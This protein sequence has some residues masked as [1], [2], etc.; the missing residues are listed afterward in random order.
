[1]ISIIDWSGSRKTAKKHPINFG[2]YS[3]LC[4]YYVSSGKET[5]LVQDILT[6]FGPITLSPQCKDELLKAF[7][8]IGLY[9]AF[10]QFEK[11]IDNY[12]W[13]VID[14]DEKDLSQIS[15]SWMG[16]AWKTEAE[17][18]K[19]SLPSLKLLRAIDPRDWLSLTAARIEEAEWYFTFDPV[20]REL[21]RFFGMNTSFY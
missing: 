5:V 18:I 4:A 8:N 14:F 11:D 2:G 19:R 6:H 10:I 17:R 1:M 7:I 12:I 16:L 3:I 21:A 9:S 15:E 13:N 20:E